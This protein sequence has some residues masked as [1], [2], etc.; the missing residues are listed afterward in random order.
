MSE[1]KR[2]GVFSVMQQAENSENLISELQLLVET[3]WNGGREE[4]GAFKKINIFTFKCLI[5]D[6]SLIISNIFWDVG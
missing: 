1:L 5:D 4:K 3:G 2:Q 6:M